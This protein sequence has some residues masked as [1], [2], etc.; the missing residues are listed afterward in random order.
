MGRYREKEVQSGEEFEESADDLRKTEDDNSSGSVITGG[1]GDLTICTLM[2]AGHVEGHSAVSQPLKSVKYEHILPQLVSVE[3]DNN[4]KGLL[5]LLNTVGGDVEAGLAIAELISSMRKPVVSMIF[6]GCHS[7]GI[8]MAVAADTSFIAESA[9]MTL[10]PV[11]ING[12]VIG[13][14]QT[15]LHFKRMQDRISDFIVKNS[16]IEKDILEKMIYASDLMAG[17]VGTIISGK[18]AVEAGLIDKLGGLADA[19]DELR[20]LSSIQKT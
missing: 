14:S 20:A 18:K 2:I 5:V 12:L 10:H 19:L 7:I 13:A 1:D 16:K 17:D 8:P 3:Q 15:F 9:T 11:R 4:I 6:G